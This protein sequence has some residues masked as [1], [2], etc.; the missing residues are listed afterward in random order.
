MSTR[1]Y[2]HN[3]VCNTA[4]KQ[5]IELQKPLNKIHG[6]HLVFYARYYSD[7]NTGFQFYTNKPYWAIRRGLDVA[8][9]G[10]YTTEGIHPWAEIHTPSFV[11]IAEDFSIYDAINVITNIKGGQEIF[12]FAF[13]CEDN[14]GLSFYLSH[15]EFLQ[16]FMVHFK[17]HA[18]DL[19]QKAEKTKITVPAHLMK[20]SPIEKNNYKENIAYLL[21]NFSLP[22]EIQEENNLLEKLTEREF[23]CLCYYLMGRTA[24]EIA[25]TLGLSAKTAS[26]HLYNTRIKLG[27][28]N[29]SEL[30]QKA[31]DFGLVHSNIIDVSKLTD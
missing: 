13:S 15:L 26:A 18:N 5:V 11:K 8:F 21:A 22:P 2:P 24:A 29:R 10:S 30:F 4:I 20:S 23:I 1:I 9:H 17:V 31:W 14:P 25:D 19:I 7:D 12:T 3:H 6:L 16:K 27:C 28:K